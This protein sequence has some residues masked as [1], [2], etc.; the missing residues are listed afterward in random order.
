M[1]PINTDKVST[2]LLEQDFEEAAAILNNSSRGAAALMR[3]CIQKLLP[4]LKDNCTD[5]R[6]YSSALMRKGLEA[7]IQQAME[8][9]QVLR[10]DSMQ[11][12][13]FESQE[14]KE[15]AF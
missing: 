8:A 13:N 4:L 5:R 10:R 2:P 14:D 7:E 15:M 6:H 9:L 3:V 1:S 12:T 11:L